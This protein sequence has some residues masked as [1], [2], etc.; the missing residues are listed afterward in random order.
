L[1]RSACCQFNP[2]LWQLLPFIALPGP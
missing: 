2:L 1:F